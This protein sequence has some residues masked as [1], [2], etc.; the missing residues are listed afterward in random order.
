MAQAFSNVCAP[1][2]PP[3][4]GSPEFPLFQPGISTRLIP[5]CSAT[6]CECDVTGVGRYRVTPQ[7]TLDRSHWIEGWIIN[8]LSTRGEVSC[9][10]HTLHD[11]A[12]GWWADAF[13]QPVGFK[14][15]SK[16]W[17]LQWAHVTNDAL[18]I[19]KQ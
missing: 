6:F 3:R 14:S 13:R 5:Q 18:I 17:T 10:E 7:G 19:A 16:L 1:P 15:G 12:G 9:D 11:R 4:C 2:P 8:Q